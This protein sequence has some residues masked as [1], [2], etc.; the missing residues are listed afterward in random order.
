MKTVGLAATTWIGEM[1]SEAHAADARQMFAT[2]T[3]NHADINATPVHLHAA[4]R[5]FL[6]TTSTALSNPDF[7]YINEENQPD[8]NKWQSQIM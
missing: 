7:S 5:E 4:T 2:Y 8:F 6:A 3:D 1:N